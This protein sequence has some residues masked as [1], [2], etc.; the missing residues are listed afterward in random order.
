PG[1]LTITRKVSVIPLD[2]GGNSAR[3]EYVPLIGKLVMFLLQQLNSTGCTPPTGSTIWAVIRAP[4]GRPARV[5]TFTIHRHSAFTFGACV[6]ALNATRSAGATGPAGAAGGRARARASTHGAASRSL[7]PA[8]LLLE[9][10]RQDAAIRTAPPRLA[11]TAPAS[12]RPP[13]VNGPR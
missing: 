6:A 5:V 8:M 7:T 4:I 13:P 10:S 1:P 2:S 3:S 12:P 9:Q 11:R